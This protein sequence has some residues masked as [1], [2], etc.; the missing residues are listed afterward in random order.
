MKNVFSNR[1]F[2]LLWLAQTI[3]QFGDSLVIM[4]LIGWART[5]RDNG[6]ATGNM[7]I[8]MLWI[9]IPI[10]LVGPIAGV[11]V[12]KLPK[13]WVMSIAA[14][15]RGACIFIMYLL[16][17]DNA[18]GA[19][20]YMMVFMI[21]TISQFF[22]TAKSTFIPKLVPRADL[23]DAN[24]A[25]ATAIIVTQILTYAV[26]GVLISK[27]GHQKAFFI[28][29]CVY[30]LV[31]IFLLFIKIDEKIEASKATQTVGDVWNDF[32]EGLKFLLKNDEIMFMVRRV[33][34]LVV[35]AGFFYVSLTGNFLDIIIRETGMKMKGIKALGFMQAFLGVGLVAGMFFT[36][37]LLKWFKETTL[38]RI[39]FPVMGLL[40]ITLYYI[41]D[42]YYLLLVAV[43]GG[44]AGVIIISLAETSI[45]KNSPENLRGRLFSAYYILRSAGLAFAS[46]FVGIMTKV[47]NEEKIILFT[48]IGMAIYGVINFI[49]LS[50]S[51]NAKKI[52]L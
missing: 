14:A 25:C 49:R 7:S 27:I 41:R 2:L 6:T 20:V 28:T 46:S 50:I 39:L 34:V 47:I 1:N 37:H 45:Q 10:V 22:I 24:S 21:S 13:K 40:V 26:A 3:E 9:A 15:A 4:S 11:F 48:G 16:T 30:A 31:I 52:K 38:I 42:F 12:D 51:N 44:I 17:T 29:A 43:A 18:R 23:L 33:F 36:S 35:A 32:M 5:M 8:L 19:Y